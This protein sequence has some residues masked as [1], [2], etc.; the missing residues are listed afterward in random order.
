[1]GNGK[2]EKVRDLTDGSILKGFFLFALPLFL[3]S[4]FQQLYGTV[5]LLFVGNF[6]G[7]SDAAAVGASQILV[8]CLIGLFSGIAVGAGVV[9]AQ[10]WGARKPE[11]VKRCVENSLIVGITGGIALTAIGLLLSHQALVWLDT[12]E[13]ILSHA[14]LYIRVYLLSILPMIL[15]NM[16]AGI[17]RALGDS[18]T[19]FYILAAGGILN[20]LMDALLIA[21][22]RWGVA[23]AALATVISQSFTAVAS[24]FCLIRREGLHKAKWEFNAA[25]AGN[26]L[27]IGFPIGLQSMLLTLSNLIVQYYINGFGEDTIAAFTVYFRVETLVY[28]PIVAF[29]QA[30]VTFTGQNLG[31]GRYERIRKGAL[32][33]NAG[34]A[35]VIAGI[36][37][38]ILCFGRQVLGAFCEEEEVVSI[39]L[40]IIHLTFPFYFIYSIMEVTGGIVRGIGKTLQS[41]AVAVVCL[42]AVRVALLAVFVPRFHSVTAVAAV[43]PITWGLT[44]ASFVAYYFLLRKK[45]LT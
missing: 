4:L 45:M 30:M 43:Y 12:P 23:G 42:C 29:G 15:Y 19:P 11:R 34:S 25:E 8:T 16:C 3:S 37:A 14:L 28:L 31:A 9:T 22:L 7:K 44:A 27:K 6:L 40:G 5:D 33:C 1:M 13:E 20:V 18:K 38:A 17:L 2:K 35:L 36:A 32:S 26:I 39:G 24:T 10:L 21:C 41:M